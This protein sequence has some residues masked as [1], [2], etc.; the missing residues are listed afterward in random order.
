MISLKKYLDLKFEATKASPARNELLD[1]A[2]LSYRAALLDMGKSG[3]RAC[4]AFGAGLQQNLTVLEKRLAGECTPPVLHDTSRE[5]TEQL[6]LFGEKASDHLKGKAQEIKDL[7]MMLARTAESLGERDHRYASH[8]NQFTTRLRAVA[9]LE[10][11]TEIRSSLMQT[12]NELKSYVDQMEQDS[13]QAI[14]HLQSRVSNYETKLKETEE[15]ALRDPLTGLP[16]RRQFERRVEFRMENRHPFCVAILDLNRFKQV[17]D[18]YGHGAGDELLKQFAQ[19]LRSNLRPVDL[20]AR[21]GGDE[22]V[23]ILDCDLPAANALLDRVRKWVF[24]D[25]SISDGRDNNKVK[26]RVTAS[27]GIA[28]WV[29]GESAQQ[30]LHRA[31]EVMYLEKA[32]RHGEAAGGKTAGIALVGS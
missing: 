31:D 5:V 27:I 9:D 8:L 3:Y 15:L 29:H 10:E 4:P 24:G 26:V 1:A 25:Y 21:W 6:S 18:R 20:V 22:F 12:A 2:M 7:L 14:A 17:N 11:L 32:R 30:L 16:N 19:E 23:V 28:E 13:Q